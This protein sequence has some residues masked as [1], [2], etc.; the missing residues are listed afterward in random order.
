MVMDLPEE[1]ILIVD[2]VRSVPL[3]YRYSEKQ[4]QIATSF[5][6]LRIE[7]GAE[8]FDHNSVRQFLSAGFTIGDS[9]LDKNIRQV[10][11]G[12]IVRIR[13]NASAQ[14]IKNQYTKISYNNID[15]DGASF[16][17]LDR[18]TSDCF[19]SLVEKANG[20][21]IAIPL[22]GGFDSRLC[23]IKL[24]EIGYD[25]IL[26]FSYGIL[27]NKEAKFSQSVADQLGISWRFAEYTHESRRQGWDSQTRRK[28][29]DFAS[30][31]SSLPHYQ[32]FFAIKQLI[33]RRE[34][35]QDAIVVPGHTG[36]F[37][38]GGHLPNFVFEKRIIDRSLI[39][40]HLTHKHFS[41][42]PGASNFD[43]LVTDRALSN[44]Y[45][46][47]FSTLKAAEI[48]DDFNLMERQAKFI[49]NSCRVYDFFGL[50]WWLPFWDKRFVDYWAAIPLSYK[51][52]RWWYRDFVCAKSAEHGISLTGNAA[53]GRFKSLRSVARHLLGLAG[54]LEEARR[55]R[56]RG[57]W[58][59]HLLDPST[60]FG[61]NFANECRKKGA[62][63]NGCFTLD[64][65]QDMG[66]I[67]G[68]PI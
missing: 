46:A 12:G 61:K 63:I 51:K 23:A 14:I 13:K 22:S 16:E 35:A 47:E 27:G 36:D 54:L 44:L 24:K 65:L 33:N 57:L 29:R 25:N 41:L 20:R 26:A 38:S 21:Q 58:T 43:Q 34:L 37:I 50:D 19:N 62:E 11:A 15:E 52:D 3:F 67:T 55:S 10:E 49:V 8:S 1:I 28:Y 68:E 30:N 42:W 6:L 4:I 60:I 17:S 45:T 9:T 56:A 7:V 31:G 40:Q 5:N 64:F 32:D 18:V 48:L 39:I 59:T 53:D 2:R 66:A